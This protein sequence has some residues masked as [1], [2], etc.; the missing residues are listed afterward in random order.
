MSRLPLVVGH[1]VE[2]QFLFTEVSNT[3][4]VAQHRCRTGEHLDTRVEFDK[5]EAVSLV[6]QF[7]SSRQDAQHVESGS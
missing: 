3:M 5:F 2:H 1:I 4:Y 6:P 7:I